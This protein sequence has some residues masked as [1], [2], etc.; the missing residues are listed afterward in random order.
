MKPEVN[1]ASGWP[2]RTGR[3]KCALTIKT[4]KRLALR[5]TSR[6]HH[7][8]MLVDNTTQHVFYSFMDGFFGY[9]QI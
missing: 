5:T 8:D 9:N 7:I 1:T 2:I 3:S 6:C 4:S